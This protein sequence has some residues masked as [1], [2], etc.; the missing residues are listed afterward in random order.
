M[1]IYREPNHTVLKQLENGYI[2]SKT[3]SKLWH[4]PR[5][6]SNIDVFPLLGDFDISGSA[7][8]IY[9]NDHG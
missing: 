5:M 6:S 2:Y 3:E 9:V 1:K 4:E 8:R 7:L